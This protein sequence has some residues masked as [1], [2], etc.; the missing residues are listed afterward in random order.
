MQTPERRPG[1]TLIELL[2]VM[3]IIGALMMISGPA[4]AFARESSER[5]VCESNLR[6]VVAAWTMYP[7]DHRGIIVNGV[8]NDTDGWVADGPG[9]GPIEQGELYTYASD[10]SVYN[11]KSDWTGNERSYS[12]IA[13]LRGEHWNTHE[14]NPDHDWIQVGTDRWD[15]IRKPSHQMVMLEEFD[16]REYNLGSWIM[17]ARN[18]YEGRW[19]D[20]MAMFHNDGT[21]LSF[22]DGH[23]EYWVWDDQ[24]TVYAS[25]N[26]QFFLNDPG[27]VDWQRVR[28][29]YR[30]LPSTSTVK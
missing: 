13:P 26:E 23:A 4:L 30:Q 6:Q 18:G 12:I 16:Y 7:I 14:T 22:A 20:Y 29:V 27:S 19:I 3:A 15:A 24:D 2:V 9:W 5:T 10:V 11:C 21:T 25:Y 28:D 17:Y 8:P 1:F